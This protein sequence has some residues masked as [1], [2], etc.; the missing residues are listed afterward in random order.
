MAD[1]SMESIL[2]ADALVLLV[3]LPSPHHRLSQEE[4]PE[5]QI[6]E[7]GPRTSDLDEQILEQ[8]A[9]GRPGLVL[10]L[11]RLASTGEY[12]MQAILRLLEEEAYRDGGFGAVPAS[13]AAVAGLE[14]QAFRATG[15]GGDGGVTGCAI[16]LEDL[17]DGEEVSAMPCGR[18]HEFHTECISKWLGCSNMCPLCRH[19][20]PT[21]Q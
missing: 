14:K 16:C 19:A 3:A 21:N 7:F 10:V 4:E 2:P 1:E 13:A 15:A 5:Q 18:G 8:Q 12:E 9:P 6:D 17:E 11:Y 20:L